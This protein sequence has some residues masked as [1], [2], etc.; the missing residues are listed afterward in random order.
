MGLRLASLPTRQSRSPATSSLLAC[1]S[2]LTRNEK[3]SQAVGCGSRMFYVLSEGGEQ[4]ISLSVTRWNSTTTHSKQ[5]KPHP[6]S[7]RLRSASGNSAAP[8]SKSGVISG[9]WPRA[10]PSPSAKRGLRTA[11]TDWTGRNFADDQIVT[12]SGLS[13]QAPALTHT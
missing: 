11:R 5:Q 1:R 3:T 12:L 8:K 6:L 13:H 9:T 7:K 10:E 4:E 2:S